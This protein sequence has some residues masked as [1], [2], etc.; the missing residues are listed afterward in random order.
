MKEWKA[1]ELDIRC[2]DACTR[3][4]LTALLISALAFSM[5]PFLARREALD[6]L[7]KYIGLRLSLM[8]I[9]DNLDSEPCWEELKSKQPSGQAPDTW[10]LSQLIEVECSSRPATAE[11]QPTSADPSP[12]PPPQQ[13]TST[14]SDEGIAPATIVRLVYPLPQLQDISDFLTAL[15]DANL[16]SRA[17]D[18]SNHFNFSIYRWE[19]LLS[20]LFMRNGGIPV[21]HIFSQEKTERPSHQYYS[22]EELLKYLTLEN[23]QKLVAYELP[24]L[25]DVESPIAQRRDFSWSLM[26]PPFNLQIATMFAELVLIFALAYFWFFCREAR[27]SETFLAP[28]TLFGVLNRTRI[29]RVVFYFLTLFPTIA[30]S[31]LA[32]ASFSEVPLNLLFAAFVV[33]FVC[34]IRHESRF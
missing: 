13:E 30:A 18:A 26:T 19:L 12:D 28:G 23:V 4:G 32:Y 21:V 5:L 29:A 14:P 2:S 15:T 20:R 10:R 25:S 3:A 24:K 11:P 33:M 6:A 1:S 7:G 16:L 8:S 17:R 9:L 31:W 22:R 34:L 27:R